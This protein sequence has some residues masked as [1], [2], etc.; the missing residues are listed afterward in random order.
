MYSFLLQANSSNKFFKSSA[1]SQTVPARVKTRIS[2]V[3]VVFRRGTRSEQ[4]GDSSNQGSQMK[5]RSVCACHLL[6]VRLG[7]SDKMHS[8]SNHTTVTTPI[9]Q[10]NPVTIREEDIIWLHM[11]VS[12]TERM[13]RLQ[14]VHFCGP[15][16]SI[17]S[18]ASNNR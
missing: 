14:G 5:R 8:L 9:V 3:A 10:Q 13:D 17:C 1:R 6:L 7:C 15:V 4:R 12:N 2:I 16:F 18:F 11:S